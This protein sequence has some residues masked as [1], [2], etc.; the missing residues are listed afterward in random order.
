[1]RARRSPETT[2]P[3]GG[4]VASQSRFKTSARKLGFNPFALVFIKNSC[5]S[6]E[7]D[8]AVK[9]DAKG[10]FSRSIHPSIKLDDSS[11][12]ES[13]PD[14]EVRSTKKRKISRKRASGKRAE[15]I[16]QTMVESWKSL[17]DEARMDR[18]A[19]NQRKESKLELKRAKQ[20][21]EERKELLAMCSELKNLGEKEKADAVWRDIQRLTTR[22]IARLE[23]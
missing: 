5:F 3:K 17:L 14:E 23:K 10:A 4:N 1:M 22:S 9:I 21:R 2:T 12:S 16:Q 8:D 18:E 15:V 20:S 19:R 11:S 6:S 13:A 7:A